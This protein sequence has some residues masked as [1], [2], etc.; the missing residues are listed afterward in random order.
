MQLRNPCLTVRIGGYARSLRL[1]PDLRWCLTNVAL[2][3]LQRWG[4]FHKRLALSLDRCTQVIGVCMRLHNH[5]VNRRFDVESV[6]FLRDGY[7]GAVS[8]FRDGQDS[9]GDGAFDGAF[10]YWSNASSDGARGPR[11]ATDDQMRLSMT[12]A[13]QSAG[14]FRPPTR[15]DTRG[16]PRCEPRHRTCASVAARGGRR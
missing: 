1:S 7:N 13:I 3:T 16:R 6:S 4:V 2:Q 14:L 9:A 12:A 5:C 11:I 10:V 8:K 15:L